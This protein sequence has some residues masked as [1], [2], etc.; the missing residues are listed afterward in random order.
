MQGVDDVFYGWSEH[1]KILRK[2]VSFQENDVF[3]INFADCIDY[4]AIKRVY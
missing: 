3:R 2:P 4:P 1:G